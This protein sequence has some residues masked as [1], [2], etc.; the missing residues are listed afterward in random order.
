MTFT[1]QCHYTDSK[2]SAWDIWCHSKFQP[3]PEPKPKPE[4]DGKKPP[5]IRLTGTGISGTFLSFSNL[6]HF[7][8][9]DKVR[10]SQELAHSL[11]SATR[12][13][14]MFKS[15]Q[16]KTLGVHLMIGA[17]LVMLVA[18]G[19]LTRP[20]YVEGT[21]LLTMSDTS[22]LLHVHVHARY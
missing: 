16:A 10:L 4:L 1:L 7:W 6:A 8:T 11:C 20:M 2:I 18:S 19:F 3:D 5:N 14:L 21:K 22:F 15:Y 12:H 9:S 13:R 17:Q